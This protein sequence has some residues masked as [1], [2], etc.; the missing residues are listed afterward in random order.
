MSTSATVPMMAPDGSIGDI[1]ISNWKEAVKAGGKVLYNVK[2][3][4]GS[5]GYIP[6][7]QLESALKAG[8]QLIPASSPD[9]KGITADDITSGIGEGLKNLAVGAVAA[10]VMMPY[11]GLKHG[12]ENFQSVRKTGKTME[13]IHNEQQKAEGHG[14][15]YRYLATPM[16]EGLGTDVSGMEEGARE[17][18]PGKVANRFSAAVTPVVASAVIE[19]VARAAGKGVNA[20]PEGPLTKKAGF[21]VGKT[22]AALRPNPSLPRATVPTE[23]P[24]PASEAAM[25][26]A[27]G[28][29]E[30]IPRT[31][32]GESALRQILTGQDNANLLKIARSRGIDV[33]EEA[34]LKPGR[35][36]SKLIDKIIDSH[37][38]EELDAVR[39]SYLENTRFRHQ[40][41]DVG[42]EAWKTM[43]LQ[44]Y[45]PDVNISKAALARTKAA[46]SQS[47]L[48]QAMPKSPAQMLFERQRA[49]STTTPESGVI[50]ALEESIRNAQ[51]KKTLAATS[52]ELSKPMQPRWAYRSRDVGETGIPHQSRAQASLDQEQVER[53]SPS[54]GDITGNDQEIVKVDLSKMKEGEDYQIMHG[55]KQPNW[56]KFL[57]PVPESAVK[58]VR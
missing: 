25:E 27:P 53:S 44:T 38:P 13:Q 16:A 8:G 3:P 22:K 30:G 33:S 47:G 51:T 32:S 48:P 45:F 42:P 28:Q 9:A 20:L 46:I 5:M 56:V 21:V 6:H 40:F 11:Q 24:V 4:D 19:P 39:D 34:A 10:P 12:W 37:S 41:G 31:L 50:P 23:A 15:L 36:D 35:A 29:G 57:K 7:D 14:V 1:P 52:Q 17:G 54:R 2:A 43:S 55:T 58:K 49:A 18:D 26:D